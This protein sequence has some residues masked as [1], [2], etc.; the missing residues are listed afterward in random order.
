[1]PSSPSGD[2]AAEDQ[3]ELRVVVNWLRELEE[4]M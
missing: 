2:P 4:R 1:M 3:A